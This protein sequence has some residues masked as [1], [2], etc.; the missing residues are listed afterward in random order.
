MRLSGGTKTISLDWSQNGGFGSLKVTGDGTYGYLAFIADN[1]AIG[2]DIRI[3]DTIV[4][5]QGG[6]PY[7]S[8]NVIGLYD[9][10]SDAVVSDPTLDWNGIKGI[11]LDNAFG[12]SGFSAATNIDGFVASQPK[13]LR[14]AGPLRIG[15]PIAPV[16]EIGS[17]DPA[18]AAEPNVTAWVLMDGPFYNTPGDPGSGFVGGQ[19]WRKMTPIGL[20]GYGKMQYQYGN[21][22]VLWDGTNWLYTNTSLGTISTGTGGDWPWQATWAT[23]YTGAKI[24]GSYVKST[25]YP[26]VP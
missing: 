20:D 24:T 8:A 7:P 2:N 5:T 18:N 16:P 9:T 26:A 4:I 10:F 12:I 14:I 3:G 13:G 21:E 23:N 15:Q 1:P 25:N 11:K 22:D 17:D 6:N 19:S